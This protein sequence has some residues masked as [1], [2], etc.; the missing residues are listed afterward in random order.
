L[1]E[2]HS[3]KKEEEGREEGKKEEDTVK[4]LHFV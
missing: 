4:G 3:R 2:F 1:I